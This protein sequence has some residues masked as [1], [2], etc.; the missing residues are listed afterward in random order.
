M[1]DYKKLCIEASMLSTNSP[2]F[3]LFKS[4]FIRSLQESHI[5][6]SKINE[7]RR[8]LNTPTGELIVRAAMFAAKKS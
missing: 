4:Q 1:S 8:I 7:F 3:V 2:E 6:E 5:E